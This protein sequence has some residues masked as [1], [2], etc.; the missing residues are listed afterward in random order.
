[1]KL[2]LDTYIWVW[3][4]ITADGDLCDCPDIEVLANTR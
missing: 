3:T 2:L 1:M 4:L